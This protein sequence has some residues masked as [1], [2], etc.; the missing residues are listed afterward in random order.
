MTL[1]SLRV[2]QDYLIALGLTSP[3]SA[4]GAGA[5]STPDDQVDISKQKQMALARIRQ[6]AAHE[7]GHTLGIAHNFAASEFGRESVMD[8]PHPLV[9]V[10]NGKISLD[11]A[12][13]VGM[14]EWDKYV[15]AYGYQNY[16]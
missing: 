4:D 14:G 9:S 11:N 8:Y 3:F 10:H 12:Y 7:V 5:A 16:P 6:L 1:G 15:V 2:K 13:D